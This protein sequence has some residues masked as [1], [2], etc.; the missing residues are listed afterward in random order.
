MAP[1]LNSYVATKNKANGHL[2]SW[3]RGGEY[4][5]EPI[6]ELFGKTWDFV[7][8]RS[9]PPLTERWDTQN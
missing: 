5:G 8:T 4:L 9:T 1:E 2:N 7:P 6:N 3:G